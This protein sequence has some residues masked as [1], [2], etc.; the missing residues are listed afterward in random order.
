M[1]IIAALFGIFIY[2]IRL[3]TVMP[4]FMNY[5]LWS[6]VFF[7]LICP[8]GIS[9]EYSLLTLLSKLIS[10]TLVKTIH[11]DSGARSFI[12]MPE[13]SMTNVLQTAKNY[14]PLVLRSDISDTLFWVASI[15]WIIVAAAAL[16]TVLIMYLL[17]TSEVKKANHIVG[18][19]YE[20]TMVTTP[21]VYGILKPRIVLPVGMEQEDLKYILAHERVHIRRRDNLWRM[22]G[23]TAACLHWFNP[24]VWVF[25]RGFLEDCELACDQSAIRDMS[26]EER[27]KY[28]HTLLSYSTKE[29]TI[30]IA[31]FG[32]SKIKVRIQHIL[33]YKR[34]TLLSSAFFI[35]MLITVVVLLLTNAS[36][37]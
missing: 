37:Y 31:A 35:G 6:I 16:L 12:R 22:L 7:R 28:A 20:G 15:L 24:L 18:N 19:L 27:K 30:F 5:S 25:L 2:L 8:V 1:S 34:L 21:M 11:L 13:L 33:S 29:A 23:I 36:H 26:R 4:K 32:S 14:Q 9:S 17:A 3:I 10:N